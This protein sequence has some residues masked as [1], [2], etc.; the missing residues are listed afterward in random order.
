M[1]GASVK[2]RGVSNSC[3]GNQ[4]LLAAEDCWMGVFLAT[5]CGPRRLVLLGKSECSLEL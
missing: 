1:V 2:L 3:V 4:S 5:C